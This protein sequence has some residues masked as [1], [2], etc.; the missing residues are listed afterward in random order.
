MPSV[1]FLFS[2]NQPCSGV[3]Q[4]VWEWGVS[5]L[6][7]THTKQQRRRR[8]WLIKNAFSKFAVCRCE[9]IKT[10]GNSER[11][12][13]CVISR[14]NIAHCGLFLNFLRSLYPSGCWAFELC[15]GSASW[16]PHE[17]RQPSLR[18]GHARCPLQLTATERTVS[19]AHQRP[20]WPRPSNISGEGFNLFTHKSKTRL[21]ESR[22]TCKYFTGRRKPSTSTRSSSVST[23]SAWI[24]WWSWLDSAVPQPSHGWASPWALIFETQI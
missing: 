14:L 7:L 15:L 21:H 4:T 18:Q 10:Q 1:G 13:T 22:L 19:A 17:P 24:S 5:P 23:A 2:F 11:S 12:E 6:S 16:W 8:E 9:Q 20:P 3:A